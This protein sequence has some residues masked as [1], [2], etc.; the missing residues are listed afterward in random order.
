MEQLHCYQQHI[1]WRILAFERLVNFSALQILK[2]H[3]FIEVYF[4]FKLKIFVGQIYTLRPQW[5]WW[6]R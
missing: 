3:K 1:Q 6:A 4:F 2:L 5:A